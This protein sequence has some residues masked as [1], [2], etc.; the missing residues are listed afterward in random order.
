MCVCVCRFVK[1]VF[2]AVYVF[3]VRIYVDYLVFVVFVVC[4]S[5]ICMYDVCGGLYV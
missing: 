4:V 5:E 1:L 2:V 3:C